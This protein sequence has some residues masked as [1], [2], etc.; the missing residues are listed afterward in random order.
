MQ[1][2]KV[3]LTS[4]LCFS[5]RYPSGAPGS[6]LPLLGNQKNSAFKSALCIAVPCIFG[7]EKGFP[8]LKTEEENS[9][10]KRKK[11]K[12][13]PIILLDLF[14]VEKETLLS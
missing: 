8:L 9:H 6:S 11:K 5:V 14:S 4:Q 3:S 12:S 2:K 1:R 10:K 13:S 7:L